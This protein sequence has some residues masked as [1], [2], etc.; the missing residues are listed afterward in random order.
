M[1]RKRLDSI[2]LLKGIAILMVIV[3]H[4]SQ[5]YKLP[6][7]IEQLCDFGQFG[8]QLFFV[9]SGYMAYLSYSSCKNPRVFYQKRFLAIAPGWHLTMLLFIFVNIVWKTLGLSYVY[10][11][12][13]SMAGL[14]INALFLNGFVPFCNNNGIPGG[15]F[16]GT[17]MIFYAICPF[18]IHLIDKVKNRGILFFIPLIA[19][20]VNIF[21]QYLVGIAVGNYELSG[22]GCFLYFNIINQLPCLICGLLLGRMDTR[23]YQGRNTLRVLAGGGIC[24]LAAYI[25]FDCDGVLIFMILPCLLGYAFAMILIGCLELENSGKKLYVRPLN[26]LGKVSF[27]VYLIHVLYAYYMTT[28]INK[29]LRRIGISNGLVIFV[30]VLLLAV[31]LTYYS[32]RFYAKAV[33]IIKR[34]LYSPLLRIENNS[35]ISSK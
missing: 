23:V 17:I 14:L 7:P 12:C 19:L 21:M 22:N 4:T 32:A 24:L 18:L 33:E 26:R 9:I 15:W 30:P 8:C 3:V 10:Q 1:M 16:I 28:I 29:V 20:L 25:L 35:V 5:K 13:H 31:F 27:S 2:D 11:E 6:A 34:K